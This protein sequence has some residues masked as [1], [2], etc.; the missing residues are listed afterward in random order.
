M[1][2]SINLCVLAILTACGPQPAGTAG[3]STGDEPVTSAD[4]ATTGASPTSAGPGDGSDGE[5]TSETPPAGACGEPQPDVADFALKL[6]IDPPLGPDNP[7]TF[8]AAYCRIDAV[9]TSDTQEGLA[10]RCM[11]DSGELVLTATYSSKHA[12]LPASAVAGVVV[13]VQYSTYDA[14]SQHSAIF[15]KAIEE[16]G[17]ILAANQGTGLL[18]FVEGMGV[19]SDFWG[20]LAVADLASGCPG[21]PGSCTTEVQRAGLQFAIDGATIDL[22]DHQLGQLGPYTVQ[23]GNVIHDLSDDNF[24]DGGSDTRQDFLLVHD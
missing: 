9:L 2:T 8:V 21:M 19:I 12:P 7:P 15:V 20:S 17:I 1:R 5:T 14:E 22:F 3:S 23:L 13:F 24:C 18:P 4:P 10:I 6:S 11:L 16:P